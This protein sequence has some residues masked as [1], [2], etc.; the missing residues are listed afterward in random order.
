MQ[1]KSRPWM[2]FSTRR[3]F[4]AATPVVLI[5]D[6][7]RRGDVDLADVVRAEFLQGHVGVGGLVG[8]VGVDQDRRLVG[9]HLLQD[10]R[11]RLALGEPLAPNLG[12]QPDG[13]GLVD[14]DGA[15]RP[16]IGKRKPVQLIEDAGMGRGRKSDHRER[17][18]MRVAQAWLESTRERLIGQQRVEVY[19]CL[20]HAHALLFGRDRR[21]KIGERSG[22]IEPAG[23]G[24]E[25]FDKL[26]HAVGAVDK[27]T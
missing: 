27:A 7:H 26:Q 24:H 1:V 17:A 12:Q 9:H 21:M 22:V 20:R 19:R 25:A 16:A 13:V 6:R 3:S 8:G 18:Q 11:D 14:Q 5:P 10:R 23:L 4:S 2:I 15:C